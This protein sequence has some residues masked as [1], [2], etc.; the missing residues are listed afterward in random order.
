[1]K[2]AKRVILYPE[3]PPITLAN[4]YRDMYGIALSLDESGE[5]SLESLGYSPCDEKT[6]KRGI[7]WLAHYESLVKNRL[8]RDGWE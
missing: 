7:K 5:I 8:R 2:K 4:L 3:E 1:M 6:Y